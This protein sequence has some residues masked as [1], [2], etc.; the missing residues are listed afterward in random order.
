[1][2]KHGHHL[3][4]VL[5]LAVEQLLHLL[6]G[7]LDVLHA[8]VLVDGVQLEGRLFI[9]DEAASLLPLQ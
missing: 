8:E 5:P 2:G 1:M 7:S 9:G 6:D 4:L 3:R